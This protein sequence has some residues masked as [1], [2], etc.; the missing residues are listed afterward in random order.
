MS[1]EEYLS[2]SIEQRFEIATEPELKTDWFWLSALKLAIKRCN[3]FTCCIDKRLMSEFDVLQ[4]Y[5]MK[6]NGRS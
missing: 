5:K 2:K 3:P 6:I 1:I 4:D